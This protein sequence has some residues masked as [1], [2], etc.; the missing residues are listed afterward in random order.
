MGTATIPAL[1]FQGTARAVVRADGRGIMET[2]AHDMG[3][4]AGTALAQIAANGL[5][6]DLDRVESGQVHPICRTPASLAAPRIPRVG[7]TK[8]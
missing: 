1:M 8:R 5:G 6:L 2:G 4:G 3:Q 7:V